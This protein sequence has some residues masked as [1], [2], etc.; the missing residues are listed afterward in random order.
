MVTVVVVLNTLISLICLYVALK[1]RKLRSRLAKIADTLTKAE[2]NTHKVL[3]KGPKTISKGQRSF[4]KLNE[5]YQRLE[6]QVKKV[7]Q[8][9]AILGLLQRLSQTSLSDRPSKIR[10]KMP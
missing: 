9:L 10:N 2:R 1:I 8:V 4:H 5:R 7:Q 6:P 3:S